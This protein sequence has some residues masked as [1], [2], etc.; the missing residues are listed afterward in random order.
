MS[1]KNG[2]EV[3]IRDLINYYESILEFRHAL[4]ISTICIYENTLRILYKVKNE[5]KN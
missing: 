4:K 3:S 1:D 5:E 2:A